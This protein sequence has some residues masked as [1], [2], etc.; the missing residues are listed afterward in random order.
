MDDLTQLHAD[1]TADLYRHRPDGAGQCV[2]CGDE[3]PCAEEWITGRAIAG[4]EARWRREAV[5][6]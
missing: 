1:A 2:G 3:Y 6:R 4:V 5:T